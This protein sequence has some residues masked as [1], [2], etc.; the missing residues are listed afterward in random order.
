LAG[1][2]PNEVKNCFQIHQ[3]HN[4]TPPSLPPSTQKN[5]LFRTTNRFEAHAQNENKNKPED[6]LDDKMPEHDVEQ[7]IKSPPPID[8]K[9]V[10]DFQGLCTELIILI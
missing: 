10:L 9:G 2:G 3:T 4:L 6:P 1:K 7:L 5:K 8:I